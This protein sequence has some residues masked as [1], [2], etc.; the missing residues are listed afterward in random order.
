MITGVVETKYLNPNFET[1]FGFL[2]SQIATSP[3]GGEYLCG[4]ELTGADILMSFPL[5][6]AKGRAGLYKEKYP[7]LWAYSERLEALEGYKRAVQ[8]IIDVEGSYSG[9]L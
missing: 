2:E 5:L 6:A 9:A 7:K 1:Q 8:K 3:D 4:T